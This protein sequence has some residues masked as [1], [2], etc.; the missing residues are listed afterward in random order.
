M[1]GF[2]RSFKAN[3]LAWSNGEGQRGEAARGSRSRK[4]GFSRVAAGRAAA[5]AGLALG[6]P[7]FSR[8]LAVEQGEDG[9][10]SFLQDLW[11]ST[12]LCTF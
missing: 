10:T 1:Q 4:R 12:S 11:N 8:Y 6:F 3:S 7:K 5:E 9:F 2:D